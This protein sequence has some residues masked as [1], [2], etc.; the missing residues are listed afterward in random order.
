LSK[1]EQQMEDGA[2]ASE[3]IIGIGLGGVL[4]QVWASR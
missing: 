1:E 3:V 4:A 2:S